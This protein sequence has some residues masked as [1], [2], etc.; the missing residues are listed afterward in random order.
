MAALLGDPFAVHAWTPLFETTVSAIA[1]G[2]AG[3]RYVEVQQSL[4]R[5][6]EQVQKAHLNFVNAVLPN[7][8]GR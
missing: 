1:S 5:T 3:A 4:T 6:P 7:L 8:P 2:P